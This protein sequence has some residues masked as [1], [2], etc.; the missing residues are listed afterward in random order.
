MWAELADG[1]ALAMLGKALAAAG[2]GTLD[3]LDE[4]LLYEPLVLAAV[5]D[6][7]RRK[8]AMQLLREV[9]PSAW[10][11]DKRV[12]LVR[13]RDSGGAQLWVT[14]V[15]CKWWRDTDSQ[16]A[17]NR[18]RGLFADFLR[19]AS[20]CDS[21]GIEGEA[22][23]VLLTTK[24][25]WQATTKSTKGD[26]PFIELLMKGVGEAGSYSMKKLKKCPA[27][28]GTLKKLKKTLVVPSTLS[29]TLVQDLNAPL[30]GD[31]R[32][33]CKV[34]RVRKPQKSKILTV[35]EIEDLLKKAPAADDN[36]NEGGNENGGKAG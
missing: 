33:Y 9:K 8:K 3:S 15:E 14:A 25:S 19:L 30:G 10:K 29:A 28:S 32:V 22:L 26:A 16:N 17:S 13:V 6:S 36:A 27:V 31:E 23:L 18:R 24:S 1:V 21:P 5:A 2:A 11:D 35:G 4:A 7:A 12:D 34:W 20:L